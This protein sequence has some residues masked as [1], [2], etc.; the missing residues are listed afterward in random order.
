MKE[1]LNILDESPYMFPNGCMLRIKRIMDGS[2][3]IQIW[4]DVLDLDWSY[5]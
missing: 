1:E 5:K 3:H 2:M 4:F